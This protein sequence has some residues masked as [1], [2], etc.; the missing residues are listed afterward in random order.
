MRLRVFVEQNE[1][2]K[3]VIGL[4]MYH[5][6]HRDEEMRQAGAVGYVSKSEVT[7]TL[8]STIRPCCKR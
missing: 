8:I 7:E 1:G 4:S 5:E 6:P 2:I 3:R